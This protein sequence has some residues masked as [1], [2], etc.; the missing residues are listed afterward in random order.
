LYDFIFDFTSADRLACTELV[1]RSYHSV[2]LVQLKLQSRAGRHCLS[3][4]DLLNQLIGP[5]WF[6]PV[7]L[8]GLDGNT[9][10]EGPEVRQRLRASFDAK[11][12]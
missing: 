4:E 10:Q 3:A 12:E 5:G 9:W 8:Y 11:F 2:G 7:L 1:Y 6:E